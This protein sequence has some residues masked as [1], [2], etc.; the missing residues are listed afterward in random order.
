MFEVHIAIIK[1]FLIILTVL[2]TL[3]KISYFFIKMEVAKL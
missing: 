1:N 3:K 2:K